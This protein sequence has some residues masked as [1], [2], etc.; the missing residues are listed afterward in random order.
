MEKS[1]GQAVGTLGMVWKEL[2]SL[3]QDAEPL[4]PHPGAP[5]PLKKKL[6][7]IIPI[8]QVGLS[9]SPRIQREFA[10]EGEAAELS[11]KFCSVGIEK[12]LK[13]KGLKSG[14]GSGI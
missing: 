10:A 5:T 14:T 11:P 9:D 13:P 4:L 12:L 2:R 3:F 8:F 7:P 1:P 6:N